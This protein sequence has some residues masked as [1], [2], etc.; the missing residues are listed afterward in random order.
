[1]VNLMRESTNEATKA[2]ASKE[3]LDRGYGKSSR[4]PATL[5]EY[6]YK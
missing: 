2:A 3:L 4:H 1:L 6:G 5:R